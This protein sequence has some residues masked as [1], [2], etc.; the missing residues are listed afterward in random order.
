MAL[1][2]VATLPRAFGRLA[3]C[4]TVSLAGNTMSRKLLLPILFFLIS[5]NPLHADVPSLAKPP[6]EQAALDEIEQFLKQPTL[7]KLKAAEKTLV[8][9]GR[10]HESQRL[11]DKL[12]EVRRRYLALAREE[13][14]DAPAWAEVLALADTWLALYPAAPVLREV[15]SLWARYGESRI[16]DGDWPGAARMLT[17]ID[18]QFV[19][20]PQA[21]ALRTALRSRAE[22]L[23]KEAWD[24]ADDQGIRH[25]QE[26]L[27]LWPRLPGVRDELA[28]RKKMYKVL[29]VGVRQLPENL[30]PATAWTDAEKQAS[31][32][33]FESLVRPHADEVVGQHYDPLLAK[34]LPVTS[35]LSRRFDLVRQ[36]YWSDG[37]RLTSAD[38]RH[39]AQ[40][41][42]Q[43]GEGSVWRDLYQVPRFEGD[44][45]RLTFT[46]RQGFWDPLDPLCF[47][48]LPQQ[49]RGKPL[50]RADDPEF[51]KAP[52]GSGPYFYAGRKKEGQR[53]FAVFQANPYYER[54]LAI[55]EVRLFAWSDPVKDLGAPVPHLVLEVPAKEFD[56]VRQAGYA[57]LR[58]LPNRRVYFLAV[59]HRVSALANP[60]LR[61]ALAHAVNR[62]K[63]LADHFRGPSA[64]K[65]Y[66]PLSGPF[67][68][69]C[70][71]WCPPPRVPEDPLQPE[72][73]RSFARKAA[74]DLGPIRLSLKYP[75]D[76]PAVKEACAA[77]ADQVAKV[78]AHVGTKIDLKLEPLAPQQMRAALH[79]RDFELAYHHWDYGDD[80]FWLWPLFDPHPDALGP[81]G[82]NYL[83]YDN[84]AKLQSLFRAALSQRHFPTV[85]DL[86]HALHAH[87][88]ER[89]PLIPLW[90]LPSNIAV[91]AALTAVDLD[92]LQ[93]F[94]SI[95]EW[96]LTN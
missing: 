90:Q 46:L 95:A 59:N 44:P 50:P 21:D 18:A 6:D 69:Q 35:G 82:S 16:K 11:A 28:K 34:E 22:T 70:W 64:A 63:I 38:I 42:S 4:P 89:M 96:K 33:L 55:R 60:D 2:Q 80:H 81:G 83:G 7:D 86:Y 49:F 66:D 73:A 65:G 84:D 52:V 48:V 36:A 75:A 56:S 61:R 53:T 26:A 14:R 92:P 23:A 27:S 39:T 30:S 20:S 72:L 77:L 94:S 85:R 68:P 91:H 62:E 13:A 79:R 58:T 71:A 8:R 43:S 37:E 41:L 19:G 12:L 1:G 47:K 76:A 15:K 31:A 87:L 54:N 51:A 10:L 29:I 45:F 78:F 25:L 67:P 3:T 24:L 88:Y 57:D 5:T 74:K 9:L 40:L 32:L 17:R 93:V